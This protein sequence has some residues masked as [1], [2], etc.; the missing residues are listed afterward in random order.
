MQFRFG[1]AL[2]EPQIVQAQSLM[3]LLIQLTALS[4]AS[5]P[6]S[7]RSWFKII[8]KFLPV[9]II[10][11]N[12]LTLTFLAC[13]APETIACERNCLENRNSCILAWRIARALRQV[14]RRWLNAFA[15][16]GPVPCE[17]QQAAA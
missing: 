16:D 1:V 4:R 9:E 14:T 17:S 10:T 13:R 6:P 5:F 12:Y 8:F 7:S 2:S 11:T 15:V 3:E